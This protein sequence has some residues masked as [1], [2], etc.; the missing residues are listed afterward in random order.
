MSCVAFV[1]V[2]IMSS[3]YYHIVSH[4]SLKSSVDMHRR[5]GLGVLAVGKRMITKKNTNATKRK[6]K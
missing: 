5:L 2:S 3:T 6:E 4:T 1:N